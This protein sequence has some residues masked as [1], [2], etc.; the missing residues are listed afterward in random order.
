VPSDE[1]LAGNVPVMDLFRLDGRV[2][3]VTGGAGLYGTQ[4]ST[5]LAEA[6]ARVVIAARR[7][8]RCQE[9]AA[10]LVARGLQAEAMPLDLT[11]EQTIVALRDRLV[12]GMGSVDVL[13][14]NAVHRQGSDPGGTSREDWEATSRVN[15]TGLFL[16]CK[17]FGEQ[18]ARQGR[19]SIVNIASIY[20]VVGPDFDVYGDTGMTSPAF[21]AY[22][23][24]GMVN[25]TRYLATC[26]AP[27]GVRVNAIS[28]G[29]L[30]SGQ[31]EEFVRN[32]SR[33]TPLGRMAGPNDLKG[34]VVFLA[35]DASAY[36]TGTNLLVDGGWTAH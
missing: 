23:K 24:G 16:M 29:G 33:R 36:V 20:G 35:S 7:L 18:M 30:L 31:P 14:N 25:L 21:Y 22:D 10:R 32:Y 6:G 12:A 17:H 3:V 26:Y 9:L 1:H 8:H 19:G 15:S 27:H 34:A 28:P 11:D 4:I 13:I 5:A 2:A